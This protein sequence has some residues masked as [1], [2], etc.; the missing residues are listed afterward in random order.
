MSS[1]IKS[2]PIK[3]LNTK[4]KQSMLK[5]CFVNKMLR[6]NFNFIIQNIQRLNPHIQLDI[7]NKLIDNTTFNN[8]GNIQDLYLNGLELNQLPDDC[9]DLEIEGNVNLSY[10]NLET[11][12]YGFEKIKI[13]GSLNCSN[14]KIQSLNDL[15]HKISVRTDIDLSKN[16]LSEFPKSF[17]KLIVRGTLDLSNNTLENDALENIPSVIIGSFIINNNIKLTSLPHTYLKMIIG[18]NFEFCGCNINE[19]IKPKP[20]IDNF[21]ENDDS[22]K[23]NDFIFIGDKIICD[24]NFKLNHIT[25]ENFQSLMYVTK[26]N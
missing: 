4:G 19:I 5:Q 24:N 23:N 9:W 20:K 21:S 1:V 12:P 8:N 6:T 17:S 3:K 26:K 18:K 2:P 16:N 7:I 15:F 14:N 10:N 11:L 25:K 22:S 13:K